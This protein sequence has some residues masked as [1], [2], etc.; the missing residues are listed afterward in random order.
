MLIDE[1]MTIKMGKNGFWTGMGLTRFT[2]FRV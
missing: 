1:E 2:D